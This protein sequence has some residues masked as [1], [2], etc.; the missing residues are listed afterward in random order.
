MYKL[1]DEYYMCQC[2]CP[3]H[4]PAAEMAHLMP[5]SENRQAIVKNKNAVTFEMSGWP[6][7][8]RRQTQGY[9]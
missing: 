6:S 5:P 9:K 3:V 8:L 2:Q 4:V 1:Q 7:G